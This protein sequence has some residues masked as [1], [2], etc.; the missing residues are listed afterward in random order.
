MH[1]VAQ[2]KA[3]VVSSRC[4][5]LV[6]VTRCYHVRASVDSACAE[7]TVPGVRQTFTL[8]VAITLLILLRS[9]LLTQ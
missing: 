8:A 1:P 2:A 6:F 3:R 5:F 7:I 9:R 4:T